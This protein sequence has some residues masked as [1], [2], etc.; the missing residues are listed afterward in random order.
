MSTFYNLALKCLKLLPPETAS[1]LSLYFLKLIHIIFIRNFESD[2]K[3]YHSSPVQMGALKFRNPLGVAAGLDK[4]GKYFSAI[5]SLG[6]SFIE[7]GTFTPYA[8]DGNDSPRIKRLNNE[9]SLINRLGFNNPGII[10][11]IKNIKNNKKY[12]SGILGV[13]I[14]KN[15]ETK[16]ED[17]YKDYLFCLRHCFEI[18]D[19]VAVNISSP[20]TEDLRELSSEGFIFDLTA[21]INEEALNLKNTF[22]KKVPIML[23]LS[24]DEDDKN[25]ENIITSASINGFDGFILT[26]TMQGERKGISGGI[27]GEL[28]K[29]KSV[30]MLKKVKN[31]VHDEKILISSGGI[32]TKND[33]EERIDNGAKLIQIYTSFVYKGPKIVKELL[34]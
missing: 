34:N 13:S 2:L 14:G 4:E 24:P 19:Y 15:K 32:S 5:G 20:N 28:L 23:K 12:F 25:L 21:K 29:D 30:N 33:L 6:F 8:Q 18:S 16:L 17:A 7:V 1:K 27:S 11:G 3:I 31:I 22:G 9:K 26:N 10:Q